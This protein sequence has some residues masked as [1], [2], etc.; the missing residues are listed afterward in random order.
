MPT[1]SLSFSPC[2]SLTLLMLSAPQY[3]S[4]S[5]MFYQLRKVE[6]TE[7]V[8]KVSIFFTL[9][10]VDR[11]QWLIV[12][13]LTALFSSCLAALGSRMHSHIPYCTIRVGPG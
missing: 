9:E 2:P 13:K 5:V 3:Y 10:H 6:L 1:V 12:I 4:S 7:A 11:E 8:S